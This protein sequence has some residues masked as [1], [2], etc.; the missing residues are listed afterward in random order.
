MPIV[1]WSSGFQACRTSPVLSVPALVEAAR[2]ERAVTGSRA[3][4]GLAETSWQ[5][6]E[7]HPRAAR[8]HD[9]YRTR[10]LV[11][12]FPA[13]AARPPDFGLGRR[14][15]S[16]IGFPGHPA[17]RRA[18]RRRYG[19]R[20]RPPNG[21]LH[22][23]SSRARTSCATARRVATKLEA[24]TNTRPT[25]DR[26]NAAHVPVAN[27][28]PGRDVA[29]LLP[30]ITPPPPTTDQFMRGRASHGLGHAS[31]ASRLVSGAGWIHQNMQ[32]GGTW[33]SVATGRFP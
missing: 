26:I 29:P 23:R 24:E 10:D 27:L 3:A 7:H 4:P 22:G 21:S 31:G 16:R 1:V 8:I 14:P 18:C 20:S 12:R 30:P 15:R 13:V 19:L 32:A 17:A 28:P 9:Q 25:D 5:G 2:R 6:I 11:S 33:G